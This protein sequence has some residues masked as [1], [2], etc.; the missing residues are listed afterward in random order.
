VRSYRYCFWDNGTMVANLL[1]T[2]TATGLPARVLMGFI[3]AQVNHLL[4]LDGHREASTCLAPL[5]QPV[6]L[7]A[8]QFSERGCQSSLKRVKGF[9]ST[10]GFA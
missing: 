3:D 4:G 8:I 1:A 7:R 2:A 6:D 10:W 9:W 5:G